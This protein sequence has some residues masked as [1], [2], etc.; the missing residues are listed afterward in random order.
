MKS[1][2]MLKSWM[3]ISRLILV[4]FLTAG[5]L[6][7][8]H[9]VHAA[10][11]RY[12]SAGVTGGSRNGSSWANAFPSLQGALNVAVAGDEIRVT[13][14]VYKPSLA[15]DVADAR[16]K[17]F[18]LKNGVKILGGYSGVLSQRDWILY[19]TILS[20]DLD[21]NDTNT[22]G[23]NISETWNDVTG[24]NAYNVVVGTDLDNTTVLDGVIVTGGYADH[25]DQDTYQSGAGVRIIGGAP[26]LKN[27][28][29][30]GNTALFF[31]FRGGG[32]FM[33][34]SSPMVEDTTVSGNFAYSG[35]GIA[36]YTNSNPTLTR[37]TIDNN[38]A[39]ALGGGMYLTMAAL[40]LNNVKVRNNVGRSSGG[41]D[42]R[43][44]TAITMTDVEF[45]ANR[46]GGLVISGSPSGAY[47]PVNITNGKFTGNHGDT[48]GGGGIRLSYV[49]ATLTNILV[50]GNYA[51]GSGGGIRVNDGSFMVTNATIARNRSSKDGDDVYIGDT[52]VT[53]R[54]SIIWENNIYQFGDTPVV[55]FLNCYRASPDPGFNDP[56]PATDAPTSAG[57]YR[58]RS[59][60]IPSVVDAGSNGYNTYQLDLD[61]L[62]RIVNG[63][64]DLG[65]FERQNQNLT[66]VEG[67]PASNGIGFYEDFLPGSE[68]PHIVP[69]SSVYLD[70]ALQPEKD[71]SEISLLATI[72]YVDQDASGANNGASWADAYLNLDTALQAAA[73]GDQI[74]VAQGVYIPAI[75]LDPTEPKSASYVLKNGVAVY[76]GFAGNETLLKQR[77]LE[78]NQ[79]IL[80]GDLEQNDIN[81][82]GN[83]TAEMV[84]D[85]VGTNAAHLIT[86]SNTTTATVLD[87]FTIT[88]GMGAGLS[89]GETTYSGDGGGLWAKNSRALELTQ[90][91]FSGNAATH[92]GAIYGYYHTQMTLSQ[93]VF[94]GN[95]ASRGGAL[96]L[97]KSADAV[98]SDSSFLENWGLTSGGAIVLEDYASVSI[99]NT[100]FDGNYT[101][102]TNSIAG[103]LEIYFD[104]QANLDQTR[105]THNSAFT[106]GAVYLVEYASL[107]MKNSELRGNQA[108]GSGGGALSVLNSN[109]DLFNVLITGNAAGG[110]GGAITMSASSDFDPSTV[111]LVN[112]TLANNKDPSSSGRSSG[113]MLWSG[114]LTLKNS[115]TWQAG[116]DNPFGGTFTS[117]N[118]STADPLFVAPVAAATAPTVTGDYHI[119]ANS[120][121]INTGSNTHLPA[122]LTT[123]LDGR[124]RI[125]N[126]LVDQGAYE[127]QSVIYVKR[128]ATGS[129]NGGSW[130][131][132]YTSLQTALANAAAG[133]E[134]WVAKGIYKPTS[135]AGRTATFTLK[136]GTFLYGGFNGDELARELRDPGGNLTVLSGDLGNNDP[137]DSVGVIRQ[138]R[139][140]ED[141]PLGSDNSYHV[142]T[143]SGAAQTTYVDGFVIT[144]G[145]ANGGGAQN[146]GGGLL[147]SS[148]G[149]FL[150]LQDILFSGNAAYNGGAVYYQNSSPTLRLGKILS[151]Y[152][153]DAGG[154]IY[155]D[156]DSTPL[157]R[158]SI[159]SGN[160]GWQGGALYNSG[161]APSLVN[162]LI[163]GNTAN[164]GGGIYNDNA[165]P[166]LTH[167]T[168]TGNYASAALGGGGMYNSN[169]GALPT[170][171]NSIIWGNLPTQITENGGLT[172]VTYTDVQGGLAGIGNTNLNPT[173][174]AP[175]TATSTAQL[176]GDY[177]L[178]KTSPLLDQASNGAVNFL[179]L[180]H[181]ILLLW[182]LDGNARIV[183][184]N[185]DGTARVDMGAYEYFDPLLKY[186]YLPV[187]KR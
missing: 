104:A 145:F 67:N 31:R 96:F 83:F 137:V 141:D 54:N 149:S 22:D 37:V 185:K 5:L 78:R 95:E 138:L 119:Q 183:D 51:F 43:S 15:R 73:A 130:A 64:I 80:S 9:L 147:V 92:G 106:A 146:N 100:V 34:A 170:V 177:H 108:W 178:Q 53:M 164:Q 18:V 62:S 93:V 151:N 68:G 47:P 79:T 172:T 12:V 131:N 4:L 175:L 114:V 180:G 63:V 50:S 150:W 109:A 33:E 48:F 90:L 26:V 115:I 74:W 142:V 124:P 19:K 132:A 139:N 176:G 135:P 111:N 156:P 89:I 101:N 46:E 107:T 59:T 13:A 126:N 167:V 171:T 98:I 165:W 61:G 2:R 129:N 140:P 76:G 153:A 133:Q 173:F 20:G 28:L 113:V 17:S 71:Q 11:I 118:S 60:A 163:S 77:N 143:C 123:D 29:V 1:Q 91:I 148:C 32:I 99:T 174:V 86:A 14:G 105:F 55:T 66:V 187:V 154:G 128:N 125:V 116:V 120:P 155:S 16:T 87:G 6:P 69:D 161:N 75:R 121:S 97:E 58:L 184:G 44:P 35:G 159:L 45:S 3:V 52:S 117:L 181:Q 84:T 23:N 42:A 122:G 7:R 24:A 57:N 49:N 127:F 25:P 169:Q 40:T 134:I 162:V 94:T 110:S 36:V 103:A 102:P 168:L 8:P 70:K 30:C 152:A 41:L 144:G 136:N 56:R 112:V 160:Y 186:V 85:L 158:E 10:S 179:H 72:R 182:D 88:A 38:Y 65:A 82:D 39:R 21:T 157:I 27:L 166:K 81:V